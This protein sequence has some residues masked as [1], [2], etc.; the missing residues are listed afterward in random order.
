MKRI[1]LLFLAATL[2]FTGQ[3][4]A[5]TYGNG[6]SEGESTAI[7]RILDAPDE[8]LG[9]TVRVEGLII[10]VCA[11]RGCWI[12]VAGDRPNEKIQVKVTDGEIVFPMS[13]TGRV[14][15]IEGIVDEVKLSREELIKYQQH[16]AEEKGKPFD[17]ASIDEGTRFIRLIGLGAE[18]NE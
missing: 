12:Y 10:E 1:T 11:K 18:I 6:I 5:K 2:L 7:S 9:K 3:A 16:L 17:P 13:A 8:Y 15:I 4:F 14:G